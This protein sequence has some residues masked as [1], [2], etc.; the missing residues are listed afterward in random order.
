MRKFACLLG[1]HETADSADRELL[2]VLEEQAVVRSRTSAMV[3]WK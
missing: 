3:R 2:E 1:E